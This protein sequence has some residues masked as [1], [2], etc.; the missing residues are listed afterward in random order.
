MKHRHMALPAFIDD[1]RRL[2]TYLVTPHPGHPHSEEM[3]DALCLITSW[4][5]IAVSIAAV[6]G[7]IAKAI[8]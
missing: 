4:I 3:L 7:V 8:I 1:E 5:L 2:L 6:V